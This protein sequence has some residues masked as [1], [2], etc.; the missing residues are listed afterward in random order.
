MN[1]K[2]ILFIYDVSDNYYIDQ[3][4][5]FFRYLGI[6]VDKVTPDFLG[7]D[8]KT[9]DYDYVFSL[10]PLSKGF[11]RLFT[12][13][14]FY[15]SNDLDFGLGLRESLKLVC[16]IIFQGYDLS[17]VID[18]YLKNDCYIENQIFEN[19][20][21]FEDENNRE[22]VQK[23]I[24]KRDNVIM[25]LEEV[26]KSSTNREIIPYLA[27]FVNSLKVDLNCMC[28]NARKNIWYDDRNLLA[29]M[30]Q[31]LKEY[32]IFN[33]LYARLFM[34]DDGY[35]CSRQSCVFSA[36]DFK[37]ASFSSYF[38]LEKWIIQKLYCEGNGNFLLC[39]DL[40]NAAQKFLVQNNVITLGTN[41]KFSFYDNY[42][43]LGFDKIGAQ[44]IKCSDYFYLTRFLYAYASSALL[45][46]YEPK[47]AVAQ[48]EVVIDTLLSIGEI[49][50]LNLGELKYLFASFRLLRNHA[51]VYSKEKNNEILT[52][53]NHYVD[54]TQKANQILSELAN[55][56]REIGYRTAAISTLNDAIHG[57]WPQSYSDIRKSCQKRLQY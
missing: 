19:T 54:E 25:E 57:I 45:S 48:A 20:D 18:I 37:K 31:Y 21:F 36:I 46:Y 23:I 22:K 44:L 41:P 4:A 9:S 28:I 11:R 12:T 5:T 32:P 53:L 29:N 14:N 40:D 2:S 30:S 39:C 34:I 27:Y 43:K 7:S 33:W 52:N 8:I 51:N 47:I 1:V 15:Y 17:N 35:R 50:S 6:M 13:K 56:Y 42:M 26:L 10:I 49:S 16:N 38:M 55:N 3:V 24:Y